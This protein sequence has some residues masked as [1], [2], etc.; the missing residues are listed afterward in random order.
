MGWRIRWELLSSWKKIAR[1]FFNT[2]SYDYVH[3]PFSMRMATREVKDILK[4]LFLVMD[5]PREYLKHKLEEELQILNSCDPSN[6]N[7]ASRKRLILLC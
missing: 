5:F 2:A 6:A 1:D 4:S 7:V 3:I